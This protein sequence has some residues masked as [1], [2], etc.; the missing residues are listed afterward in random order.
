MAQGTSPRAGR[1][2]LCHPR[3]VN[4]LHHWYCNREAWKQHVR[5]ELVP[6]TIDDVDLGENVLEVGPGFGPA[7]EVLSQRVPRLTALEL[8][9][10]LAAPLRGRLGDRAEIV[11]GDGTD[12][13][14]ADSTFSAAVCFT[15]L[16]HVPSPEAQDR[17]FAEVGRV[18]R[19]GGTFA[20]TDSTGRGPGF[21]LLHIGDTKVVLDPDE[22]PS[23]L[24]AAGFQNTTV[25][26]DRDTVW[27]RATV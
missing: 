26:L 10:V 9:P 2:G 5:E 24:A 7:T 18:L 3:R 27:F 19:P 23:R 25:R 21:A 22:L 17:L 15:M 8:D 16:H 12:M 11:Q 20:G 4:R 6:P 14:F 13:P 1:A